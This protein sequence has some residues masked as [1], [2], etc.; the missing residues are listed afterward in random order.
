MKTVSRQREYDVQIKILVLLRIKENMIV[1]V[2]STT[3]K[4]LNIW[5]KIRGDSKG[6]DE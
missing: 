1:C 3:R 5:L 4:M 6:K 2:Q